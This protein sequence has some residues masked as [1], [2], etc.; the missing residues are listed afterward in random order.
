MRARNRWF[1]AA[2]PALTLALVLVG[3][4]CCGD[5]PPP[6]TP[7]DEATPAPAE[8]AAAAAPGFHPREVTIGPDAL[9]ATFTAPDDGPARPAVI[10]LHQLGSTRAEWETTG[11][12]QRLNAR[13]VVTLAL[14]M[15]G[16]GEPPAGGKEQ[17]AFGDADWDKVPHDVADAVAWLADQPVVDS[18]QVRLIGSSIGANACLLAFH[19]NTRLNGLV[20]LS[21]GLPAYRS[22]NIEQAMELNLG[23]PVL[24]VASVTDSHRA[25]DARTLAQASPSVQTTIVPGGRHGVSMLDTDALR[26]AV[27]DLLAEPPAPNL[28]TSP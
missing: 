10:L 1:G 27:V 8:A 15:R 28:P 12:I 11:I 19:D 16:H 6:Y 23:R 24:I 2:L 5:I 26:D 21:P 3:A 18:G 25:E 9:P 22:L 4:A 13:G 17:G 7:P 20:L 14:D